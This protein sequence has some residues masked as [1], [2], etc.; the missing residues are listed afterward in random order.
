M[1]LLHV[2]NSLVTMAL[3][4]KC[5]SDLAGQG[6]ESHQYWACP[7][8]TLFFFRTP[9]V[10]IVKSGLNTSSTKPPEGPHAFLVQ[11]RRQR[12]PTSVNAT[13]HREPRLHLSILSGPHPEEYATTPGIE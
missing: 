3:L 12:H 6:E 1:Y 10:V 9:S 8:Q 13:I 5:P 2:F 4:P 11:H 7:C